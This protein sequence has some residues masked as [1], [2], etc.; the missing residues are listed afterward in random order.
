MVEAVRAVS[1]GAP[2][3]AVG[4]SQEG[5]M[6]VPA[7]ALE[8]APA[9]AGGLRALIEALRVRQWAK[10]VFVLAGVVFAGRL[11]DQDAVLRSLAAFAAFCAASS[12]MYLVNDVLD[13]KNDAHHPTKRLRP[14]ADGRL[15][16]P[17]ALGAAALMAGAAAGGAA[18]L[19]QRFLA[20]LLGY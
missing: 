20:F 11:F 18:L 16:V 10:N 7:P 5:R 13:R 4:G 17:A 2:P 19:S 9:R 8:I 1:P 3:A 6:S 15:P 14:V 12:A